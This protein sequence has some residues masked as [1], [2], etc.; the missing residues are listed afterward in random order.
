MTSTDVVASLS[1]TVLKWIADISIITKTK[2]DLATASVE[3]EIKYWMSMERSMNFVDGQ[4]KYPEVELT[5]D[6]LK[7]AKKFNI[8]TQFERNYLYLIF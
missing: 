3:D 4:L 8:T 2:F 1:N 5:M 6:A 7:A